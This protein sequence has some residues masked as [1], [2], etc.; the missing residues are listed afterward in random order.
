MKKNKFVLIF[1]LI[2]STFFM[3][4]INVNAES[5]ADQNNKTDCDNLGCNWNIRNSKCT[6]TPS[7]TTSNTSCDWSS[8]GLCNR[9]TGCTWSNNECKANGELNDDTETTTPSTPNS[10]DEDIVVNPTKAATCE[11]IIGDAGVSLV[12]IFIVVIRIFTPILLIALSAKDFMAAVPAQD[13]EATMKAWKTMGTRAIITIIIMLLPTF[14]N[15]I[16][17][18]FNMFD[19]CSIW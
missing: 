1:M 3:M 15:V 16:G 10:Y 14:I 11:K 13:E 5:C 2:I 17:K 7:S 6:G 18:M 4:N 12:K 19:S 8:P 9:E